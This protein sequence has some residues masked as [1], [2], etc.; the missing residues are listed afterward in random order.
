MPAVPAIFTGTIEPLTGKAELI[1]AMEKFIAVSGYTIEEL[2]IDKPWGGGFRFKGSDADRFLHEFF[3][4]LDPLE[5]RAGMQNAELSPKFLLV[6]PGQRLSWQYHNLRT[7]VWRFLTPGAYKKSLSDEEGEVTSVNTGDI[8]SFSQ[9]ERHRLIGA[10]N[11]YT[12]VA[13]IWQHT[14]PKQLSSEDDIIRL[15][16]DYKRV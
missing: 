4:G 2:T 15:Q 1:R 11:G 5:V 14:D 7:E 9:G 16:D 10:P 3:P 12:L 6:L 13:E 8:V